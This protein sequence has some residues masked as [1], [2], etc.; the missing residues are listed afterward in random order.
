MSLAEQP[1]ADSVFSVSEV[2]RHLRN[3]LESNLPSF[4][5][6]GEVANFTA[7]AS[8]HWYFSLKDADA[9]LRCV[10]FKQWN[11]LTGFT[12]ADGDKLICGGRITVYEKGGAYQLNVERVLASGA[13]DL[14][15]RFEL[16]KR[17]LEEEGLFD[18]ARKRPLPPWPETV[19]VVTSSTG[20]AWQD[21]RNVMARRW[22]CRVLLYPARVQGEYAPAELM[23]G[24][25]HFN[26]AADVD[27]IILGRGGGSQEDLFVFN[28]E[29]LV[30][31][32][33]ASRIPVISA[34]GHEID[35]TLCDFAADLRA[36]TPSAAAELVCPDRNEVLGALAALERRMRNN[37]ER[38]TQR[39][40]LGVERLER[41]L[42]E[43]HPRRRLQGFQQR[44]DEARLRLGHSTGQHLAGRRGKLEL[45]TR[46]LN[47]LSPLAAM[48]RGYAI[49]RS[50]ERVVRSVDELAAG[51]MVELLL[52]DG[53]ALC[54]T[55]SVDKHPLW[56]RHSLD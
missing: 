32:V 36:P 22:P 13:G 39:R 23:R 17:K 54:E 18:A 30:R 55:R 46:R 14:Q 40:R 31:A 45:L 11:R 5:V 51:R 56:E 38:E 47:D 20:A 48:Q 52:K 4:F 21:I 35:F 15:R 9:T 24:L 3:V 34:V 33:A 8:G 26:R 49:L 50:G 19:G 16:L 44:L 43:H 28:D 27:V 37:A 53:R 41:R 7:H 25:E 10:C 6:Q 2:T 42:A 12:P 29:A 1:P